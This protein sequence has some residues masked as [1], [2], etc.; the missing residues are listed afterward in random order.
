MEQPFEALKS[1]SW[2]FI[3]RNFAIS[4]A[5]ESICDCSKFMDHFIKALNSANVLLL[6]LDKNFYVEGLHDK[7][8]KHV[9]L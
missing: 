6:T 8:T 3:V 7:Q 2:I 5:H 4:K 1:E 9:F